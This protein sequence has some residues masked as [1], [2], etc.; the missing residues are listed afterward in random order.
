MSDSSS[1]A[2]DSS[3]SVS[4]DSSSLSVSD[5]SCSNQV[6]QTPITRQSNRKNTENNQKLSA[7]ELF[8]QISR[9]IAA[10][11]EHQLLTYEGVDSETGSE[12]AYSL[13]EDRR[14][15]VVGHRVGYNSYTQTLHI[16][17]M[18]NFIHD[19]HQPWLSEEKVRM[20]LSGFI[21]AAESRLL[22]IYSGTTIT[23]FGPPYISSSKQ[24]DQ[25]IIPQNEDIPTVVVEAGWTE[26]V[27]KLHQ[28]TSL[29]LK[30]GAGFVQV[31]L[32]IKWTKITG[33]RVKAFIEVYDLDPTGNK[34]LLQTETILPTP[35]TT[36]AQVITITR[37][38]LFGSAIPAG[39]NPA[40]TFD[41]SVDDL[42]TIAVR[43]I[44]KAGL[45]PA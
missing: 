8:I 27:P 37:G 13:D 7:L 26:S 34:R 35:I 5:D 44:R 38:Q 31:V 10:A 29:W 6:K 24:P 41:L 30:G 12:V 40:D 23:N 2:S 17:I 21:T 14:V 36:T 9:T 20:I 42:R 25:A 19:C 28:D 15:E 32:L 33:K 45:F 18:P 39:R 3:S 11:T 22:E 1:S 4:D 16:N 43:R